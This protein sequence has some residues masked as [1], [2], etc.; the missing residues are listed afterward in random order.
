MTVIKHEVVDAITENKHEIEVILDR[1]GLSICLN[2][3]QE[4]ITLDMSG[5]D[6][7]VYYCPNSG[8][9][10]DKPRAT[11]SEGNMPTV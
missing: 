6:L 11:L 8:D 2:G 7:S 5:G 9:I 4:Y 10:D 3:N 1:H